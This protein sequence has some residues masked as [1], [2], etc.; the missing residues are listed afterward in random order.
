LEASAAFRLARPND[1]PAEGV[2]RIIELRCGIEAQMAA[3]AA[4]RRTAAEMAEI[5]RAL[6]A[7]GTGKRIY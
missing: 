5:K 3:L 2:L 7:I 4:L 6:K 1:N